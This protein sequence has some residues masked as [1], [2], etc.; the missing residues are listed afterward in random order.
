MGSEHFYYRPERVRYP[1]YEFRLGEY[2]LN[3]LS[4]PLTVEEM[5]REMPILQFRVM[6][7]F[8]LIVIVTV[9]VLALRS[10]LLKWLLPGDNR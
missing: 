9:L 8:A 3:F 5:E 6:L 2:R 7:F 4:E 1:I 10:M